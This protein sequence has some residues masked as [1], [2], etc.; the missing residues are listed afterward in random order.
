[1]VKSYPSLQNSFYLFFKLNLGF[2]TFFIPKDDSL[3]VGIR[4]GIQARSHVPASLCET[5]LDF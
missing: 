4:S 1:M 5:L 3:E 2:E